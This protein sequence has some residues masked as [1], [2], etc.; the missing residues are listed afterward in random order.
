[1]TTINQ[2]LNE[3]FS[4][5]IPP[6]PPPTLPIF[7]SPLFPHKQLSHTQSL[8]SFPAVTSPR[9]TPYQY[10]NR[11]SSTFLSSPYSTSIFPHFPQSPFSLHFPMATPELE[12]SHSPVLPDSPASPIVLERN[13]YCRDEREGGVARLW[14]LFNQSN[15]KPKSA[16]SKLQDNSMCFL[17][18]LKD[19]W[20]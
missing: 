17:I 18:S 5:K 1:M 10:P 8:S 11:Y 19:L 20:C 6:S 3:K 16:C 12:R 14:A 2:L 4:N 9:F 7:P 15:H 13:E